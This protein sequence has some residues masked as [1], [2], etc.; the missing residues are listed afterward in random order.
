MAVTPNTDEAFLR[1]VDEGLRR[2][3]VARLSRKWGRVAAVAVVAGLVLL[4]GW[5]WWRHHREVV[6]GED[7]EKLQQAFDAIGARKLADADKPLAELAESRSPG[8]RIAATLAQA[9][10]LL[11]RGDLK[12]AVAKF[13]SVANDA[14]AATP[15][16]ELAL[17]RQTA[18]E[19]DTLAPAA[20]VA[21][22]KPLAVKENA[23]FGSAGEMVG[24]AYLRLGRRADAG[25]LFGAVARDEAVPTTIRQRAVQLAG[26]LGVDAVDQRENR[27]SR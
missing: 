9:D 1:E 21:R 11:E 20:V 16:R 2:D 17:I 8:Y 15:Y 19:Y 6:A 3:Q 26:V 5:L 24:V 10:L 13:A 7:G 23:F 25:A 4:A 22:L 18:A 27:I 14:S 12:G